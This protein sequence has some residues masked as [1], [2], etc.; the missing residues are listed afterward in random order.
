MVDLMQRYFNGFGDKGCCFEDLKPYLELKNAE[1][2][3]WTSF[4]KSMQT[5]TVG[6]DYISSL[7]TY[8]MSC[9]PQS[10]EPGFR[11]TINVHLLL[12]RN[13]PTSEITPELESSRASQYLQ[14]YL[15]A[16]KLGTSLPNTE[17]QPADDLAILAAQVFVNIWRLTEDDAPLYNA[18]CLL[19][20]GLTRSAQSFKMRLLLV[21]IY[22][23]LGQSFRVGSR[24]RCILRLG[25]VRCF[26]TSS[27]TLSCDRG[28]AGPERHIVTFCAITSIDFFTRCDWGS[29]VS[30]GMHRVESDLYG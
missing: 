1:L 10:T 2:S 21:R 30:F 4:L 5:C 12:R 14:E 17:L 26:V 18:A 27:R 29:H 11:R 7:H 13:L 15:E 8:W 19:E 22:N 24:L 20:F 6:C 9:L 16:L 28:K 25:C 3:K 23:L